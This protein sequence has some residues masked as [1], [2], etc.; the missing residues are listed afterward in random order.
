MVEVDRGHKALCPLSGERR[1]CS[2]LEKGRTERRDESSRLGLTPPRSPLDIATSRRCV[3]HIAWRRTAESSGFEILNYENLDR[4]MAHGCYF[5]LAELAG[6]HDFCSADG[7]PLSEGYTY[8]SVAAANREMYLCAATHFTLLTI[9]IQRPY[10]TGRRSVSAS[11]G[12]STFEFKGLSASA[13]CSTLHV[14]DGG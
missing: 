14:G 13:S 9:A 10:D 4:H 11:G 3:G 6:Q 5:Q 12:W 1:T 7:T 8:S 2:C